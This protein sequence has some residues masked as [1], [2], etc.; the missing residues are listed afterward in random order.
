[1]VSKYYN[2]HYCTFLFVPQVLLTILI[3][4]ATCS[5]DI[6]A[7][8]VGYDHDLNQSLT[9]FSILNFTDSRKVIADDK[10]P[11]Y[12]LVM[13]PYPDVSPFSPSW[14]GGPAVVPAAIVA[15][16]LINQR[17]DILRDY[18]LELVVIDSGC[19][20]STKAVNGLLKE[21]LHSDKSNI[22]GIIGPGCSEAT[23]ATATLITDDHISLI[24][25]APSAT[26]PDFTNT[27]RYPNTFRPIVSALGIVATY[28]EFIRERGYACVGALYEG[29]RPFHA[30]VYT[31]FQDRAQK[32][33]INLIAFGLFTVNF[34]LDEFHHRVRVIFVFASSG[35]SRQLL[36]SAYHKN[37]RYP[38]YQFV[39]SN[40]NPTDFYQDVTV[41][42]S[43]VRCSR[44]EMK[45]VVTGMIFSDFRLR[46]HDV[47]ENSTH[48]GISFAEFNTTYTQVLNCHLDSEMLNSS[49][50]D[51]TEHHSGY[52][53]A[54]WALALSLNNSLPRLKRKGLSLSNYAYQMPEVTRV[55]KEE[56]LSLSFE[57]MRGRIEF[58]RETNDCTNSTIID[59]FQVFN[60][61]ERNY[62]LVGEY[63]PSLQGS[64]LRF[65]KTDL[66]LTQAYFDLNYVIPDYSI[67]VLVVIA[68]LLLLIVLLSCHVAYIVWRQYKTIKASSPRLAHLIFAGCYSTIGG[69]I[70]H[71]NTYVFINVSE[72][73]REL[74][75]AHC[76]A[77]HWVVSL[78][79]PLVFGTLCVK[80]WR[81]YIIFYKYTSPLTEHLND[82]ILV[83]FVLLPLAF[84][85]V[86]N[87]LWSTI[88]PWHFDYMQGPHLLNALAACRSDNQLAWTIVI[89]VPP[90]ILTVLV[91]YLAI[92]TRGVH[93]EEFKETK[94][95]NVF[96]FCL[97]LLNGA[98]L[99]LSFILRQGV[100]HYW[101]IVF[102]YVCFCT[103]LLGSA[104]LYI[105]F[106]I[107]PPLIPLIKD[108]I[109]LIYHRKT[110]LPTPA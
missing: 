94:S 104:L 86:L 68:A 10:M 95:I 54:T 3:R 37:M 82:K 83:L 96:L 48:P 81:V 62:M 15:K 90:G 6:N 52:F 24:Q 67:G 4:G 74:F 42:S 19:N 99:P 17:D 66:L 23:R 106:L 63:N 91:V 69:T 70:L 55:I 16:D 87:I 56:L 45:S 79:S 103:W 26:S 109:H 46:R 71:T 27:T 107:F 2:A 75:T 60:T 100:I 9:D 44:R 36:C 102:S 38:D 20:V 108:K 61:S 13:A 57:G 1:M 76:F 47:F 18:K 93:K 92:A 49:D 84:N 78:I 88:N 39:F 64:P 97:L 43:G 30:T 50:A 105:V 5:L 110:I 101:R 65:F 89:T 28:I 41:R 59:L 34:P 35:F 32:E 21:V 29:G 53:D 33:G 40:R 51:Y 98:C 77:L 11:L 25:I 72:K 85:V 58:S 14:K 12:F 7:T 8:Q 80:T 22:V 73:T 31:S